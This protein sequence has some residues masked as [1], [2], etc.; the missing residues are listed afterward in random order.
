MNIGMHVYL[1]ELVCLFYSGK[2][3]EVKLLDPEALSSSTSSYCCCS[4]AKSCLTFCD[5]MDCSTPG[6]PGLSISQVFLRFLS[7]E[8]VMLSNHLI[9]WHSLLLPL[10][11]PS[12][13]VFSN[14]VNCSHLVARILELRLQ[15]QSLH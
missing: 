9:L 5:P 7:I 13:R 15:H 2:Y 1:V 6:F 3:T 8:P 4:V 12:I 14:R 11:L 10:V